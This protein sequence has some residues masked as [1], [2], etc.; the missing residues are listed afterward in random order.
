MQHMTG[1]RTM[2]NNQEIDQAYSRAVHNDSMA[3]YPAIYAG[4]V[5]KG[6]PPEQVHP[7]QNVFTFK[8]WL[9]SGR[10]VKRGETGVAIVTWIPQEKDGQTVMRPKPAKVFH[11]TQ[12]QEIAK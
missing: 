11:I 12:T 1:D 7:R 9:K 6:I 4:F 2:R 10:V 5:A 3:N 8:A